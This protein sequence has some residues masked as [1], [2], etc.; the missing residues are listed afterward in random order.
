MN[1]LIPDEI[2]VEGRW[3]V[4]QVNTSTGRFV[5]IDFMIRLILILDKIIEHDF[6]V[7]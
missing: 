4:S 2:Y 5:D 7:F 1:G 6:S 3:D